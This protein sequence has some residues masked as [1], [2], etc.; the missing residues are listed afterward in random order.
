MPRQG[1]AEVVVQNHGHSSNAAHS[2]AAAN[3]SPG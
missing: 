2:P 3:L 1:P